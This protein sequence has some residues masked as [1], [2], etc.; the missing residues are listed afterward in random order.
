MLHFVLLHSIHSIFTCTGVRRRSKG[1][2]GARGPWPPPNKNFGEPPTFWCRK[3]LFKDVFHNTDDVGIFRR[4]IF[5]PQTTQV[6]NAKSILENLRRGL[7]MAKW[8]M[9]FQ[10]T[11]LP[12]P[13]SCCCGLHCDRLLSRSGRCA[14][15]EKNSYTPMFGA[16]VHGVR[17]RYSPGFN[18]NTPFSSTHKRN[19]GTVESLY[20]GT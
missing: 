1:G 8:K 10:N 6:N 16:C 4:D 7:R 9:T 3:A 19:S 18:V 17:V 13:A 15:V 12:L 2:G 5:C 20:S 14:W 11:P